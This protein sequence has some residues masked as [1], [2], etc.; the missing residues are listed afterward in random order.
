MVIRE[1]HIDGYSDGSGYGIVAEFCEH[2]K[3]TSDSIKL[4]NNMD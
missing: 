3:E 1:I 2:D 4:S